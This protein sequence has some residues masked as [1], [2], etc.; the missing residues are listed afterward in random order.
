[1]KSSSM[2][3]IS[4]GL[5]GLGGSVL[6][7]LMVYELHT[8]VANLALTTLSCDAGGCR[9][10]LSTQPDHV[11]ET[12]VREAPYEIPDRPLPCSPL[13]TGLLHHSD[14]AKPSPLHSRPMPPS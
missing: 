5:P 11:P 14:P 7:S 3:V 2:R 12:I 13:S 8:F 6:V 4:S 1:M 10:P 9:S